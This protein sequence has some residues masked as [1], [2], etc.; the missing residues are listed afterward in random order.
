MNN[1]KDLRE[2]N[3]FSQQ[4]LADKVGVHKNT[5]INWETGATDP[6]S[7]DLVKLSHVFGCTIE[8][9]VLPHVRYRVTFATCET[10]H[11]WTGVL[12]CSIDE[13]IETFRDEYPCYKIVAV[14]EALRFDLLVLALDRLCSEARIEFNDYYKKRAAVA[15]ERDAC[16]PDVPGGGE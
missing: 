14:E 3:G 10:N 2:K 4:E 11:E 12:A 8:D 9:I 5:A 13:A 15:I 16:P 1:I 7:A 6:K